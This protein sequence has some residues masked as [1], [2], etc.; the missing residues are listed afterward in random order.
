M[1]RTRVRGRR[2]LYAVRPRDESRHA[3]RKIRGAVSMKIAIEHSKSMQHS[4]GEKEAKDSQST[5][6]GLMKGTAI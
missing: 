2:K 6:R 5:E 3:V 4:G 1:D